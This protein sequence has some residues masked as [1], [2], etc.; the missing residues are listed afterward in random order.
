MYNGDINKWK[1]FVYAILARS[2]NHLS[3]KAVYK[4]DSVIFYC[5]KAISNNAENAVVKYASTGQS[6]NSNFLGP[7]RNN[8]GSSSTSIPVRQGAFI[9]NLLKGT[10]SAFP[11][12]DDPRKWYLIRPSIN[13]TF[14]G[15]PWNQGNTGIVDAN[16]RPEN[17]WGSR[18]DSLVPPVNDSRARYVFRNGSPTPVLTASEVQFMKAEAAYRKGD[19][20]TAL[21]AYRKGIELNFDMLQSDFSTNI[22]TANL[23]TAGVRDAFLANTAVVPTSSANL[24]LSHI[25]LQKYIS[26]FVH[27]AIETWVD[28]RRYHYTDVKDGF[29][30]YRD[31]VPPPPTNGTAGL[32]PDN[33]NKLVYR[34]RYRYNSEYFYN[35][36]ELK[37]FG[38]DLLDWHTVPMWFMEP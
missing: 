7:L 37:T 2:Y 27:G 21:T 33:N 16:E 24:T 36:S 29:Q 15:L 4:P 30:V 25:M 3:N 11:A 31:F 14:N 9:V 22:P 18:W 17:F 35:L 23:L 26:L 38:A 32:F 1:K 10:N 20:G 8:I 28:M 19:K 5:D 6:G 12:V 13:G 34:V